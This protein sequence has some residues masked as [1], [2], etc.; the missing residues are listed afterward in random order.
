MKHLYFFVTACFCYSLLDAQMSST[1]TSTPATIIT[2]F[3]GKNVTITGL[4]IGGNGAPQLADAMGIFTGGKSNLSSPNIGLESGFV[5]TTGNAGNVNPNSSVKGP[6]NSQ[7]SIQGDGV[8]EVDTD[9]ELLTELDKYDRKFITFT[10][11]PSSSVLTGTIVFGSEEYP[12]YVGS[13]FNDASA[14][15]IDGPGI[16]SNGAYSDLDANAATPSRNLA[17]FASGAA[18]TINQVNS[19][20]RGDGSDATTPINVNNSEFYVRNYTGSDADAQGTEGGFPNLQPNGFTRPMTFR[21]AVIP[22]Q[23]YRMKIVIADVGD[24]TFDSQMFFK[25]LSSNSG[26]RDFGDL[27]AS[28][29][30]NDQQ[31][32]SDNATAIGVLDSSLLQ[33]M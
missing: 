15:I 11:V 19:G 2:A 17:V 6:N 24:G 14:I 28:F 20:I 33:A 1:S 29:N 5:M 8:P 7:A 21:V 22:G 30:A 4:T 12:Q 31:I 13:E 16:I 27:P 18:L 10:I 26:D 9:L 3:S 32:V 25:L 23:S